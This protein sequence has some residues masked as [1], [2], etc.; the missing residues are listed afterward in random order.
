MTQHK[1]VTFRVRMKGSTFLQ[2]NSLAL[3]AIATYAGYPEGKGEY[4]TL[5]ETV[6]GLKIEVLPGA[7]D[8]LSG[9]DEEEYLTEEY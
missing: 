1:G 7:F 2:A 4:F 5:L 8:E 3:A 9:A 6:D